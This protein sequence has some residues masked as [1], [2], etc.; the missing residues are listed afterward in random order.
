[1]VSYNKIALERVKFSY[2]NANEC[3]GFCF[4]LCGGVHSHI[5][6]VSWLAS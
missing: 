4:Q 1:M 6:S 3:D 2:Y 5:I